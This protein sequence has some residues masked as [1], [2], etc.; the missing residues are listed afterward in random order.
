VATF[1]LSE[2]VL[3]IFLDA[4][5]YSMYQTVWVALLKLNHFLIYL[6]AM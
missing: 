1:S 5:T 4:E 6:V 2:G 3:L